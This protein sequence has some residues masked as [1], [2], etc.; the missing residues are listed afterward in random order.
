MGSPPPK[1]VHKRVMKTKLFKQ[2]LE[3]VVFAI[4]GIQNPLRAEIRQKGLAM[5]AKYVGDWNSSCTHLIC[6]FIN[7]PKFNQVAAV[8]GRIV[9]KDWVEECHRQRKRF[10]WRRFCLDKRDQGEESEE[11]VWELLEETEAGPSNRGATSTQ[12]CDTDE[13]IERVKNENVE[14]NTARMDSY[15]LDTDE[16]IEK[17][18]REQTENKKEEINTVKVGTVREMKKDNKMLKQKNALPHSHEADTDE[19]IDNVQKGEKLQSHSYECETDED[20]EKDMVDSKRKDIKPKHSDYNIDETRRTKRIDV[21]GRNTDEF[22]EKIP[23]VIKKEKNTGNQENGIINGTTLKTVVQDSKP[24][25][26][27]TDEEVERKFD[28]DDEAYNA[29]ADIDDC[30]VETYRPKTDCIK[31]PV[32]SRY[33]KSKQFYLHGH[34]SDG[35][36]TLLKRYIVGFGGRVSS[37]CEEDDIVL[38]AGELDSKLRNLRQEKKVADI[39]RP[40]WVFACCDKNGVV[41]CSKYRVT[42]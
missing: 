42:D 30:E 8:K 35:Q 14:R 36:M 17:V 15:E 1:K 41:D 11:E 23:E 39:L 20:V 9:K 31:M 37:S 29:D 24:Y 38:A 19:E 2:L 10:P 32:L 25:D 27:D 28:S 22:E 33:F 4:S 34:F 40:D 7:T 18:R 16:E 3:G 21:G 5:G 6:A 12:D 26:E 13:E